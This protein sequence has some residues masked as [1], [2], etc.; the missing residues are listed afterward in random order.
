MQRIF[1][2]KG[3]LCLL[4][5]ANGKPVSGILAEG[6]PVMVDVKYELKPSPQQP[7]QVDIYGW[8]LFGLGQTRDRLVL[9]NGVVLTGRT[10]GGG[11]GGERNELN[12]VRLVDIEERKIELYPTTAGA[13]FPKIDA[14]LLGVVSTYARSSHTAFA[15]KELRAQDFPLA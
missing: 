10:I 2:A 14:V 3:K 1:R 8:N 11:I 4:E 12:R 5:D 9:A 13:S 6:R 7:L 15:Q